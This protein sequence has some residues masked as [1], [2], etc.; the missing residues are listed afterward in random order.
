MQLIIKGNKN[1]EDARKIEKLK[2]IT[3]RSNHQRLQKIKYFQKNK[4]SERLP[5]TTTT[6]AEKNENFFYWK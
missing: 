5:Q 2:K 4:C 6:L 1:Q 3:K